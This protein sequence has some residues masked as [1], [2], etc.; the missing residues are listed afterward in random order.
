MPDNRAYLYYVFK[1]V[2]KRY[3][4][5]VDDRNIKQIGKT[6]VVYRKYRVQN[7]SLI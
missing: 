2:G 1:T 3:Y 5:E 7:L 4:R 6:T